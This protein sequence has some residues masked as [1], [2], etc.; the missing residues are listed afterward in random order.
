VSEPALIEEFP[1]H[2][3]LKVKSDNSMEIPG[4]EL[5]IYVSDRDIL[6]QQPGSAVLT[7]CISG[8]EMTVMGDQKIRVSTVSM[9]H[10]KRDEMITFLR[11]A[12]AILK[13]HGG[14]PS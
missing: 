1:G 6:G 9:T 11:R 2:V 7:L 3:S 4:T 5:G 13:G 14:R 10:V 12:L 8:P